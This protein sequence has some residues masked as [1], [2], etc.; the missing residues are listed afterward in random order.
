MSS[1]ESLASR[2]YRVCLA[3]A[4]ELAPPPISVTAGPSAPPPGI[5]TDEPDC[6]GVGHTQVTQRYIQV[7]P[8]CV[9]CGSGS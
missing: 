5:A 3:T 1:A 7:F 9:R 6:V 8:N 4:G 2:L